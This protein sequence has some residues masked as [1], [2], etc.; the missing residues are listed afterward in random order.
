[1]AFYSPFPH[2]ESKAFQCS[3]REP[4]GGERRKTLGYTAN[5]GDKT[6][7]LEVSF[8]LFTLSEFRAGK[9]V[10]NGTGRR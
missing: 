2:T 6:Q 10:L 4:G 9:G 7:A 1:M 3:K 5:T 8:V